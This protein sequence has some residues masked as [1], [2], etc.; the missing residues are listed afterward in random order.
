[1]ELFLPDF[2]NRWLFTL[3]AEAGIEM[4]DKGGAND[5]AVRMPA[6]HFKGFM[7]MDSKAD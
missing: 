4:T 5:S 2:I 1:M 7:I 3:P 6:S